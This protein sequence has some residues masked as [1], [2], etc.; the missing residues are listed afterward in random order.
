MQSTV[1]DTVTTSKLDVVK[2]LASL[3]VNG[4][5][6]L[7]AAEA[8]SL[9]HTTTLSLISDPLFDQAVASYQLA[10]KQQSL[11]AHDDNLDN[12]EAKVLN[13]IEEGID[14][15]AKPADAVKL[16]TALNSA[17]RRSAGRVK[18]ENAAG[19][20]V[21]MLEL[22]KFITQM[23]EVPH[24]EVVTTEDNQIIEVAGRSLITQTSDSVLAQL[25]EQTKKD[26]L[27]ERVSK[28]LDDH[29]IP[30]EPAAPAVP[31]APPVPPLADRPLLDAAVAAGERGDLRQA[32]YLMDREQSA[33]DQGKADL[34]NGKA[35]KLQ[36]TADS[37][38][39][40]IAKDDLEDFQ[41]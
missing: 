27:A 18:D 39:A 24:V 13:A 36:H 20:T 32:K 4:L 37:S 30:A 35:L 34:V 23:Q 9:S 17:K 26:L 31:P 16:F 2:K 19:D 8:L 22:P 5:Q 11:E 33:I 14:A 41:I 40:A 1:P 25:N 15:F 10:D 29:T 3:V 38:L 6:P 21:V 28:L 12:L 7:E